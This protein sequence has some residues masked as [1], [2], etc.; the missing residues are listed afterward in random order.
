MLVWL[1][2]LAI[3]LSLGL[4]GGGGSILT[5]PLL[6][7]GFGLGTKSAM[8]TSLLVVGVT[9]ALATL[10]YLRRG[11]VC[12]RVGMVFGIAA[13]L[14][15]YGG[16]SAARVVPGY[17][18]LALFVMMMLGTAF[19]MLRGRPENEETPIAPCAKAAV[20]PRAK[21]L[22]NGLAV[23]GLTGLVGAGGGFLVVPALHLLGGL[24][25][26]QAIGSS[27]LVVAMQSLAG[28]AAY[29]QQEEVDYTLAGIITLLAAAG[30]LLGSLLAG[31]LGAMRLRQGFGLLILGIAGYTLYRE[32]PW[33]WAS[34]LLCGSP[35]SP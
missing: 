20:L 6:I 32:M 23:G 2:T 10:P 26:R 28:F 34:S 17:V 19:A 29:A 3:G 12:P 11:Q 33:V 1:A 27:V 7:Y 31:R 35:G 8:A 22:L 30:T 4:L 18:L 15:A 5:V 21:I 14:G 16:G 9:S 24:P 25:I 13:M